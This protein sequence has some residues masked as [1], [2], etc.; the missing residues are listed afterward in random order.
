MIT[1]VSAER[2]NRLFPA[3]IGNEEWTSGSEWIMQLAAEDLGR[4]RFAFLGELVVPSI[5]T[6]IEGSAEQGFIGRTLYRG[7]VAVNGLLADNLASLYL[8]DDEQLIRDFNL[9]TLWA[10]M[11]EHERKV[12]ELLVDTDS[13]QTPADAARDVFS[14]IR[15]NHD[16][17]PYF[18]IP[19][20][21]AYAWG[22]TGDITQFVR[23]GGEQHIHPVSGAETVISMPRRIQ[24]LRT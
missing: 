23:K 1:E 2:S 20:A 13:H 9:G 21:H 12:R 22:R 6:V 8:P 18:A 3:S 15:L 11:P 4:S 19:A 7:Q 5:T 17:K 16:L 10:E 14:R 24:P